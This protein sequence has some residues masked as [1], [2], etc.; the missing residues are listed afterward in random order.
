MA[1]SLQ[2]CFQDLDQDPPFNYPEQ[3]APPEYN[4]L[5]LFLPFEGDTKDASD[6][7][8]YFLT[9]PVGNITFPD[10][11]SGKSYK[12]GDGM[13]VLGDPANSLGTIMLADTLRKF[14]GITVAFWMNLPSAVKAGAQNIFSI[15]HKTKGWGN[16]DIFTDGDG[17][18]V[19][20]H[21]FNKRTGTLKD[22]WVDYP[23]TGVVDR[24]AHYVIRYD[25]ATSICNIFID[26]EIKVT[27]TIADFGDLEFETPTSYI[28]GNWGQNATPA[29]SPALG[30]WAVSF[31]GQLD[32]FRLYN[33]A[34]T[35]SQAK[36]LFTNKK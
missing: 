15:P 19:K 27:A 5:K 21:F 26:G 25:G 17:A 8:N 34:L 10:G 30:S 6:Y 9:T 4:P 22:G 33:T 18:K 7:K 28:L 3:P 12:G 31:K 1:P 36:E 23:N 35:D 32:Q 29:L 13:Y 24:W 11:I 2:S 16:L 14:K 20:I